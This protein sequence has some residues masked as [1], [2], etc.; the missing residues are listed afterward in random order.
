MFIGLNIQN[1]LSKKW[2]FLVAMV[3]IG[4]IKRI[5]QVSE[6]FVRPFLVVYSFVSIVGATMN[7][8]L[9]WDISDT[10]NGL[11]AVPN[12]IALLMLSG[13]VKKLAMEVDQAEKD[14]AI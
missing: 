9:L 1:R 7:L 10:F 14:G 6:K 4:G 3:L 13:H 5:G 2:P 8:G 12:L 11:M